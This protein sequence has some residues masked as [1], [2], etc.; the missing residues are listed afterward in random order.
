MPKRIVCSGSKYRL[1]HDSVLAVR[2]P[3]HLRE[4]AFRGKDVDVFH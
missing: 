2:R 4:F 1:G 3:P